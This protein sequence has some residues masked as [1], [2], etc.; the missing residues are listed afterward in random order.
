M[1]D[2][3]DIGANL[4]HESFDKDRDDVIKTAKDHDVL[5]MVITGADHESSQQSLKLAQAYPS[6]LFAT[7]GVHPH[8][9]SEC[10]NDTIPLLTD[11]ALHEENK[12]IGECGLDYNRDFSPRDTQRKWFEKQLALACD[13]KKPIFLHE[14]DA[15]PDF[16][17]ILK[18]FID[19]LPAYVVHCF[20]GEKAE[21]EQYLEMGCHIG[22]TGWICDERRGHHL[23]EFVSIIPDDKLMIETDAPY[24][25]PRDLKPKPKHRRNLP[26]YLPHI[27]QRI[28][29]LRGETFDEL[30]KHTYQ[31][32]Q[33]FF[34]LGQAN[35]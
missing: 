34:D 4:T 25:L 11:L 17:A 10:N 6:Q 23:H 15:S 27:A 33:H 12:A 21:L 29:D 7:A 9:A 8:C 18:D 31:T 22:I 26:E 2:F 3:I 24:L 19:D 1:S 35:K 13:L 16:I 14:R 5:Q 30:K 20:T 32:T 28:A